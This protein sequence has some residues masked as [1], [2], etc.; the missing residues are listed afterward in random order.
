MAANNTNDNLSIDTKLI[1]YYK[2]NNTNDNLNFLDATNNGLVAVSSNLMETIIPD[3]SRL[4][5]FPFGGTN[6]LSV[7][8][9]DV[10]LSTPSTL[11][12]TFWVQFS[13]NYNNSNINYW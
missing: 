8:L 6:T 2:F 4:C 3:S 7:D 12:L 11:T 10:L 5:P 9:T 1:A 13:E